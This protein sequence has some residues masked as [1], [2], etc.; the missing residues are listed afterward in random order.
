MSGLLELAILGFLN[1]GP[2][3]GY[4]LKQ[5]L[6]MLMGHVRPISD[7]ALYPAIA[8]LERQGLLTRTPEPGEAGAPRLV[9]RLTPAGQAEFLRRLAAPDETDISDQSRFF[10]Y[11]AFL[12]V[13]SPQ[14]QRAIL[15]RRLAFLEGAR[16]FFTA[17]G[18]P[19][20][21]AAE[22]DPYRRGMLLIAREMT[23]VEKDWLRQQLAAFGGEAQ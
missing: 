14:E 18:R 15:E 13:L 2:A 6:M 1:E 11:L 17:G 10:T 22:S 9:L 5:R 20:P 23:R 12:T 4:E 7:G 21:L 19:V 3:H 8:R 16:S